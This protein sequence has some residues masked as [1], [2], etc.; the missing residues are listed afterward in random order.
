M[1]KREILIGMALIAVSML[2]FLTVFEIVLR[3]QE[4]PVNGPNVFRESDDDKLIYEMAPSIVSEFNNVA[5]T[6]NSYGMRDKEY[7]FKKKSGVK[8]IAVIGDSVAAAI[9]V[10]AEQGYTEVLEENLN[11][12]GDGDVEVLNFGVN[13]Y[14]IE[15]ELEMYKTRALVFDLDIA[16]FGYV[17]NDPLPSP[18][19]VSDFKRMDD[20][21]MQSC[22]IY[23]LNLA[24][25]CSVRNMMDSLRIVK[26]I[27]AH[28]L[29]IR[30]K[31]GD[32]VYTSLHK[33][34]QSW[35]NV[36]DSFRE[37]GKISRERNIT[38]IIFILPIF[39][40]DMDDYQYG[41]IH[42][43]VADEARK[44]GLL[45]RDLREDFSSYKSEDVR[46]SQND[47]VHLNVAGHQIAAKAI[48]SYLMENGIIR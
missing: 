24:V 20:Q 9:E 46:A 37:I 11:K 45:V 47:V 25:P 16:I 1:S 13:G 30:S 28:I 17:L 18:G 26:F 5:I 32:D 6:T 10:P 3:V 2:V 15:Q 12:H 44:N 4:G 41:W 39:Y 21:K 42:Q 22:K 8:R 38:T 33:N 36:E 43:K 19:L 35:R 7:D 27:H 29:Q 34:N 14:G 48:E 23:S 31:I 40:T